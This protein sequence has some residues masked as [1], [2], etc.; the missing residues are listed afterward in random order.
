MKNAGQGTIKISSKRIF[1]SSTI[2]QTVPYIIYKYIVEDTF[3][4]LCI[5]KAQEY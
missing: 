3:I 2:L 1:L 4:I 5:K